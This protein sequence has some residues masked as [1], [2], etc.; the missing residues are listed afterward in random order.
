MTSHQDGAQRAVGIRDV[1]RMAGVSVASASFALN[2]QPGVAQDTRARIVAAAREL[3][4][5]ANPQAQALRRGRTSTYGFVIRNFANPFFLEGLTGAEEVAG[6]AGATLLALDSRYSLDRERQHVQEMAGQRL[7]GLAIAPVGTGE[8]I[9]LWQEL[10]PGTPVVAV[11][12]SAPGASGVSRVRPDNGAAVELPV[13]RLAELGHTSVAFLS[14]PR[15]LM[16]D[17]DRLRHFRR[18]CRAL[19]LRG[20]VLYS[21]LTIPDVQRAVAARLAGPDAPTA[22]ITNSDY[23][24]HAVYK[25]ARELGLRVG[26]DVSVVGHDDLATS[27]LLDPPLATIGL[28]RREM[29][30]AL[31]RRL[32]GGAA[33]DDYI[34]PVRL[35]ERASVQQPVIGRTGAVAAR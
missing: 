10:R 1:A 18:L 4:Y 25:A 22:V 28:D 35:I 13:R 7:A 17:P 26:P 32:L 31:M 5:R 11:N 24:A 20:S 19:G 9:G 15:S 3:G 8:S 34:A 30:R 2:G 29:G 27:E 33:P 12:A 6:K 23:T 21:P 14:A 16:A